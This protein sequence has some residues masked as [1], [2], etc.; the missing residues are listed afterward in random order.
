MKEMPNFLY[1]RPEFLCE[2]TLW[3][4]EWILQTKM[5]RRGCQQKLFVSD[6][7][8]EIFSEAF[9]ERYLFSFH[10]YT[11]I[12][13]RINMSG[14]NSK[15]PMHP[16]NERGG[17]F[18]AMKECADGRKNGKPVVQSDNIGIVPVGFNP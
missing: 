8:K 11:N 10:H 16:C 2:W 14:I 12:I 5:M 3:D 9:A 6:L 18:E 1:E 17:F 15:A 13:K 4:D 7:L